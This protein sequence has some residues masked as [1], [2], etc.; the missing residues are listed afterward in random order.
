MTDPPR[1]R[2]GRMRAATVAALTAVVVLSLLLAAWLTPGIGA[3]RID[4]GLDLLSPP[5]QDPVLL[6]TDGGEAR[7]PIPLRRVADEFARRLSFFGVKP[8]GEK[9]PLSRGY[10]LYVECPRSRILQ[11]VD[12]PRGWA[13]QGGRLAARPGANSLHWVGLADDVTLRL[14][15]SPRSGIAKVS[16]ARGTKILD[17]Y[18][19]RGGSYQIV[20]A[21]PKATLVRYIARVARG[22]AGRLRLVL[23]ADSRY[24]IFRLYMASLVPVIAYPDWK[25]SLPPWG[26]V[27]RDWPA[28]P[29]GEPIR[30]PA[31]PA[32]ERGGG[33]T[34]AAVFVVAALALFGLGGAGWMAWRL[35][36]WLVTTP[37]SSRSL[38]PFRAGPFLSLFVPLAATWLLYLGAYWP[39][40]MSNDSLDQWRQAETMRL[41][42]WHPAFHTLTLKAIA[43]LWHSPAAVALAQILLMSALA[44]WGYSLLLRAGVAWGVVLAA[45]LATLLS[46][47]NGMM[48]LV[49][50]KDVFYSI[51]MFAFTLLLAGRLLDSRIGAKA[52]GWVLLGA[53]LG[54]IPLY[55]H[56][57]LIVLAGFL[58]ALPLAFWPRRRMA[59]LA[60]V[61]ALCLFVGVKKGLYPLLHVKPQTIAS[62]AVETRLAVLRNQDVPFAQEDLERLRRVGAL[63]AEWV[64]APAASQPAA[65]NAPASPLPGP[66]ARSFI[67]AL[68]RRY[69]LVLLR[70]R[71]RTGMYLYWPPEP[72]GRP[73]ALAQRTIAPNNQGLAMRPLL[74]GLHDGLETLLDWTAKP[75]LVWLAW[76]PALDLWAVAA[77]MAILLWRMRDFR[78]LIV[79]LPVLLN[80][81]GLFLVGL[82]QEQ[83]Y[84]FPL[85]FAAGFLACLALLPRGA[86]V[87]GPKPR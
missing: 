45:W 51:A 9:N 47:R 20:P 48:A 72:A 81:A 36:R 80:T 11:F 85:T 65:E 52:R 82:S 25:P 26:I 76:R 28:E 49:L 59:L 22:E 19:P 4:V 53:A 30:L 7:A 58:P 60:C 42:D 64:S 27:R 55:R 87:Q 83:R 61:V 1:I 40:A 6:W 84:Q 10:E 71:F 23:P 54:V 2:S 75:Q 70:E 21:P 62:H 46:P 56:N 79:Y 34:F 67:L 77:A 66:E 33:A 8:T 78:F 24:R 50:W 5:E 12:L 39:G 43:T 3:A 69:P 14:Y 35:L 15:Q 13:R 44:A 68:A 41:N 57:G 32:W 63:P 37:E 74:P 18:D 16:T 17:L 86:P 38:A 29:A 31:I 73:M